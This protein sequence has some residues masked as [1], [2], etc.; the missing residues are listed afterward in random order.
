MAEEAP[1]NLEDMSC[2][3]LLRELARISSEHDR[4]NT[5]VATPDQASPD[6]QPQVA[7]MHRESE[8]M[9]RIGDLLKEKGC[10]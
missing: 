4:I 3:E 1:R 10:T 8:R 2:E 9:Q 7:T 5:Q 6:Q